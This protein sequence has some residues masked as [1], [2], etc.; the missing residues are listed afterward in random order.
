MTKQLEVLRNK[1]N[2]ELVVAYQ[3]IDLDDYE[4]L[5]VDEFIE[6]VEN[7]DM[8]SDIDD[9]VYAKALDEYELNYDS[10]DDP[11]TMWSDFLG[12]VNNGK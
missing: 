6:E 5:T 8:W 4:Y 7:A 1:E 11:E 2:Q 12:V 10:Y 9:E 3:G